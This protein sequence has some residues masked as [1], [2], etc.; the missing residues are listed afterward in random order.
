M[1]RTQVGLSRLVSCES[2]PSSMACQVETKGF[3]LVLDSEILAT[4]QDTESVLEQIQQLF[5]LAKEALDQE[6][7]KQTTPPNRTKE[8]RPKPPQQAGKF[9]QSPTG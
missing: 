2:N 9:A 5:E 6:I 4:V 1:L 8:Q 7:A 3:S